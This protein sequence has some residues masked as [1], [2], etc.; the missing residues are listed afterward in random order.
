VS[1][2]PGSHL[3]LVLVAAVAENGVIGRA[4]GLPW[5]LKTD[6]KHFRGLTAGHPV[7]IGRRTYLA[8]GRP[9]RGRTNIVVTRDPAFAGA[10]IVAAPS[11]AAALDVARGDALRRG[12]AA[13]MIAGGADLYAQLIG[14]AA[15]LEITRVHARPQGDAV[16]PAID[17]AQWRET[18]RHEHP[19]GPDD[20]APFA[21]LTYERNSE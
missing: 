10:G 16:F 9:L 19:A 7:V 13:I 17:P 15:R 21:T 11:L 6:M 8:I 20:D 18:S 3:P 4:G 2:M 5:R 1:A 14:S 12:V